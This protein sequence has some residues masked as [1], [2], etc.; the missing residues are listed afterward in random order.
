M[1]KVM[2]KCLAIEADLPK[3]LRPCALKTS[4]YMRNRC[5]KTRT[6]T[7]RLNFRN[8][9]MFG[10]T[11]Y[12]Y[13]RHRKMLDARSDKG[14]FVW[15]DGESSA[16]LVHILER[17]V[18]KEILQYKHARMFQEGDDNFWQEPES[19]EDISDTRKGG[20]QDVKDDTHHDEDTVEEPDVRYQ[21]RTLKPPKQ[22]KDYVVGDDVEAMDT[23]RSIRSHFLRGK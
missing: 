17:E 16:C 13:Q 14:I 12:A 15:Y 18:I 7:R 3:Q 8:L 6:L 23:A 22:L 20:E 9:D 11:C 10:E 21:S 19:E 4:P 5:F 1:A 2:A